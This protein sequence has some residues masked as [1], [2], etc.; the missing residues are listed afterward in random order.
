MRSSSHATPSE[1]A[2]AMSAEPLVD[3]PEAFDGELPICVKCDKGVAV[4]EQGSFCKK[5]KQVVH[6]A[7]VSTYKGVSRKHSKDKK[8]AAW[9]DSL[10]A[11]EVRDYYLARRQANVVGTRHGTDSLVFRSAQFKEQSVDEDEIHTYFPF[12][13]HKDNQES[14]GI[15]DERE[16][17]ASLQKML[18]DPSMKVIKRKGVLHVGRYMGINIKKRKRTVRQAGH[19]Q[20]GL[21]AHA[22]G[23]EQGH[24]ERVQR[25][26]SRRQT[27][28]PCSPRTKQL[29]QMKLLLVSPP[30]TF[31]GAATRT[32]TTSSFC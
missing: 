6:A 7:C 1:A 31:W 16:I 17:K 21:A 25:S 27:N 30:S 28:L 8:W 11:A 15:F 32:R 13:V 23:R 22:R 18:V 4:K 20:D 5:S 2:D 3:E 10:S 24:G 12:S 9:W 19:E 26:S 29:C 14:K